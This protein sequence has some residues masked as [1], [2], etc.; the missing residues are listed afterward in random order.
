MSVERLLHVSEGWFRLLLR[1]YPRDFRDEMGEGLL[2]AYR[3]RA[4]EALR[5]GGVLSLGLVWFRALVD[6]LRNGPGERARPAASWRRSGNWGRDIEMATRRLVRAPG[7]ALAMVGTL[8]VGLGTFAVVYTFVQKILIDPMP[9]RDPDNLYFVWRDYTAFFDLNRGWLGGTDV[10]ELQK[11]GG[12]IEDAAGLLRQQVTFAPREGVDATEIAVMVT[13][14]NLFDLLGARPALGRGFA[15]TEV[16]PGRPPVIVLTHELW[17]RLG[18]DPATVGSSVRLNGE[19]YTVIGVTAPKFA[20]VRNASLGPPQAAD[21][22][23]TFSLD[24]GR[25]NPGAGSYAGLIRA[26][27]GTSPEV[28]A[29]AV[30]AIG[31]AIDARDF[32]NRGL[33][34]YPVNLKRDL[35]AEVRPALVVLGLAATVLVLTLMVNLGSVLLARAARREHEF[36]V[37][38][39]LGADSAAVVRA[40]LLEGGLLGLAG[41][42]AGSLA[43]IWGTRVLLALAPLD[44]PRKEAVAVDWSIGASVTG[45]GV[46]LG[47]LAGIA[48]AL[49][50]S[51]A[52]LSSLLASSAVR[53]GGGHARMRRSLV[54]AQV[55]LSLVLLSAAGLVARSFERILHADPGFNPE[56]VL[57]LRVPMPPQLFSMVPEAQAAQDRILEVLAAISGVRGVSATSSV[58][59]TAGSNQSTITIPGAPGLTGDRD[60]DAPLVDYIG[61]RA[62]YAKVMGIEVVSGREFEKTRP[63]GVI[64][65][66][67][68]TSLARQF[69]PTGNPLG[70]KIPF[71]DRS[72]TIVG[73]FRQA[74][75]YDIHKD[76]RPQLFVRA[77]DGGYRTLSYVLRADRDPR[78][79]IPEVRAAI[80]R[81]D[82]R[83][84]LAGVRTMEEIEQ[85]AV[86][87]QRVSAVLIGGFAA[88]ALL[89]AAMGL[90][91]VV[92]GSVTRRRHE[93]AV[94]LALGAAHGRVLRLVIGEGLKLV[95]I[96]LLI[97]APGIYLAG[98]L[99]RG[100][101]V[102][103]SPLDPL[104]LAAVA[105]GLGLVA[106]VAC[107]VPARR[108][109]AIDPAS[110]LRAD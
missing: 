2:E 18:A 105:A 90:V 31:K 37:S 67:I 4:R 5:R 85:D 36:A 29:A 51:R 1:L 79:L 103:V 58:P 38:R 24:L 102:G 56:G 70:A 28:V 40:M 73:V 91:G 76:G 25:T 86:R 87:Q 104:T 35:V 45:L 30:S 80:R 99:I 61:T 20:F 6:S 49:W 60:R 77:E 33:K 43:A 83:L 46:L 64:E 88:G 95:A 3:D 10:V 50:A 84:A 96:G 72:L 57:T 93:I 26:Q 94:R 39:A 17:N 97:G 7:L 23:T 11:A 101:L 107:Y 71:G 59:L 21:A 52:P 66:M 22:Y 62:G 13:T 8:A 74:R 89:L 34:L 110:S 12:P 19:P 14:P 53:G 42:I 98:G 47:L 48:P 55:A 69:F 65:A 108:V 41:G 44:L 81:V 63:Q 16:G 15:R 54:V 82:P 100:V 109:L 9:Y 68:D 106:T 27:P 92:S 75:L 32:K 78:T